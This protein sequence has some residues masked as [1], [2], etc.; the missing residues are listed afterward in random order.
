MVAIKAA[1]ADKFVQSPDKVVAAVLIYGP[2]T[3]LVA[4]RARVLAAAFAKRAG[5]DAE[6][7]RVEE[8]DLDKDPDRLQIEL[9]TIPMFGGGKVVRTTAGRKINAALFKDVFASGQ[10]TAALVCEA[11]NLK[12]SDAI[13]KLFEST[14]FAAAV[15]CYA[16]SDRDI[17][18]LA[19]EMTA[20]AGLSLSKD[21]L[22]LLAARLGADR[23]LT[24]S[25]IDKLILYC[26]G[27]KE[28]SADDILA[29][30]GD[31]TET[32]LEEI[33]VAAAN[34]EPEKVVADF[35][36]AINAGEN[37]QTVILIALRYFQRL[38]RLSAQV[39]QG[40]SA[41]EALRS[42]RPPVHFSVRDALARQ[43]R[44]W[45]TA[46][47]GDALERLD[48]AQLQA[49]LKGGMDDTLGERVLFNLAS[50]ARRLRRR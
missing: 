27:K 10:P 38:H 36:R 46:A 12:A 22:D 32:G 19:T 21:N 14:E 33:A 40:K 3:G 24:R 18:Q 5:G 42:L 49:R 26:T 1:Q 29:I 7:I 6:I 8:S 23:A 9:Q 17:A 39:D 15:A 4:E 35:D 31:A 13:R 16:D 11:G 48:Q 43:V 37:P 44:M 20:A 30:V 45:S 2:D 47:L 50:H 41:E 28:I 34:G 25:E